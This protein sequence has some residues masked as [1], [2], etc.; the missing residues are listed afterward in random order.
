MQTSLHKNSTF[1]NNDLV[2]DTLI[3]SPHCQITV[4]EIIKNQILKEQKNA[5]PRTLFRTVVFPIELSYI[6][7]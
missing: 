4:N 6:F 1:G 2:K 3:H 5:S 7:L